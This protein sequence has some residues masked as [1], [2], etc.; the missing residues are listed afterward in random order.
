M[1]QVLIFSVISWIG[2]FAIAFGVHE[3]RDEI[4]VA[5]KQEVAAVEA[6]PDE[7]DTRLCEA[8][9]EAA[10]Q[11]ASTERGAGLAFSAGYPQ[12][13]ESALARYCH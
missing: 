2:A 8:A 13:I 3:W 6:G 10:G 7:A 1:R 9:L 11:F 5:V 12:D 4:P